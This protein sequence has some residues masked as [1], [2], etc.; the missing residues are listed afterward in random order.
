MPKVRG[1]DVGVMPPGGV[2]DAAEHGVASRAVDEPGTERTEEQDALLAAL[3]GR[4][5]P[6]A[7]GG[8]ML[9]GI[10]YFP[11]DGMFQAMV[12]LARKAS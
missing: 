1:R 3:P 8:V 11:A 10:P 12:E 2:P 9:D 5:Y 7:N 6:I 4:V